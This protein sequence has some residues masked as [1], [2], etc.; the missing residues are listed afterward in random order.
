MEERGGKDKER[1]TGTKWCEVKIGSQRGSWQYTI[2]CVTNLPVDTDNL[3]TTLPYM[4]FNRS[5]C[6]HHLPPLA[7]CLPMTLSWIHDS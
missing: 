1:S 6:Y 2:T 7:Y 3:K 5:Q 4:R